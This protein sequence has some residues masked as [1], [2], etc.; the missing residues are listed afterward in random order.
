MMQRGLFEGSQYKL[1]I[2]HEDRVV[3][4]SRAPKARSPSSRSVEIEDGHWYR[5][6]CTRSG[7]DVTFSVS[8]MEADD[9]TA[10][11]DKKSGA[12][13]S[14]DPVDASLPLSVGGKLNADGGIVEDSTDQFNGLLDNILLDIQ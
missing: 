7:N 4:E 12:T 10:I 2:D 5:L 1:Q 6:R 14:L 3:P 8:D 13:G 11:E 9:S